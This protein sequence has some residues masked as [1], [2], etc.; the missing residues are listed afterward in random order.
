MYSLTLEQATWWTDNFLTL[1]RKILS[2]SGYSGRGIWLGERRG[3][4]TSFWRDF[5]CQYNSSFRIISVMY[6]KP[7]GHAQLTSA[8]D[9]A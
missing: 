8:I 5:G 9:E 3:S 4:L 1:N 7:S 2:R 6:G